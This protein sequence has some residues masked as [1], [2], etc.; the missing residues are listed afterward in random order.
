MKPY[1][2]LHWFGNSPRKRISFLLEEYRFYRFPPRSDVH[3]FQYPMDVIAYRKFGKIQVYCDFFIR[4]AFGDKIDEFALPK[5][6]IRWSSRGLAET[7]FRQQG[8]P[9]KQCCA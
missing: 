4:E 7:W 1:N 6:Q 5:S 9:M 2:S 3:L 8:N